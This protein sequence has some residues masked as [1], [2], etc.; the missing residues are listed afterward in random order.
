[1]RTRL[2]PL[3]ERPSGPVSVD[4]PPVDCMPK[5]NG[6]RGRPT[7]RPPLRFHK[8]HNRFYGPVDSTTTTDKRTAYT[9][10]LTCPA[11]G[12]CATTITGSGDSQTI[13]VTGYKFTGS[14]QASPAVTA[15]DGVSGRERH[16]GARLRRGHVR[17]YRN[18]QD[19]DAG[20]RHG[21]RHHQLRGRVR[22]AQ[23]VER[24]AIAS[25]SGAG[26]DA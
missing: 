16:G 19:G 25:G 22:R 18:R 15:S 2:P 17:R 13:A 1:M 9:G 3:T 26:A 4:D 10:T 20:R 24:S 14:R 21:R 11:A 6:R 5:R 7:R 8:A 23:A 12:S